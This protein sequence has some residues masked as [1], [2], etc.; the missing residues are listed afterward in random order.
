MMAK[1]DWCRIFT[2]TAVVFTATL[3]WMAEPCIAKDGK[4]TYK[5][6]FTSRKIDQEIKKGSR[7]GPIRRGLRFPWTL[8]AICRSVIL[9]LMEMCRK[10]R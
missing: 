9:I 6:G 5:K 3:V 2:V 1:R 10:V 7:A 8:C 4:Y